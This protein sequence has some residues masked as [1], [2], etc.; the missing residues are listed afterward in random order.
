MVGS[1]ATPNGHPGSVQ[2]KG[3]GFEG[4]VK[5]A[6]DRVTCISWGV[7]S[8]EVEKV[9]EEIDAEEMARNKMQDEE[10]GSTQ[11]MAGWIG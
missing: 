7:V 4:T 5:A 10:A 11:S 1:K 6:G 9:D 8:V 3:D 2:E